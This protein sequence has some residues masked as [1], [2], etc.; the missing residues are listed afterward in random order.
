[1]LDDSLDLEIIERR[2]AATS[3][4]QQVVQAI[5]ALARAQ[6]P[7]VD[8][9][10]AEATA[11]LDW[12]DDVVRALAGAPRAGHERARLWVVLGPERAYCGGLARHIL[13]QVPAVGRVGLV[14]SRLVEA[15]AGDRSVAQ[16]VVFTQGGATSTDDA[17]DVGYAIAT[18]VLDA[19]M[20]S[21]VDLLY[22]I[23]GSAVLHRVVLLAGEVEAAPNPPETYSP[24]PEVLDAAVAE[25]LTGR[26]AIG[27][28]E[29]LRSEVHARIVA[30][31]QARL[32]CDKRLEG[33]HERWRVARQER[34]T[35]ELLEVVAGSQATQP[36]G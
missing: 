10:V 21:Q 32:A 20:G 17:D 34:I 13:D 11:Y 29:A 9:A 2:I 25:A 5:W 24:L 23:G 18:A 12:V 30:A 36:I 14:G 6:L 33:L 3:A 31:D 27:A 22:P 35:T 1:M 4:V 26:L 7:R 8:S 15:S 28:L 19:A 16:R